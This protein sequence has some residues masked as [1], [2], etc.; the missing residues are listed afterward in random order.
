MV[1]FGGLHEEAPT[2]HL[3]VYY[4]DTNQWEDMT[5][6]MRGQVPSPRFGHSCVVIS[7]TGDMII[8]GGSD[9]NDLF[10]NGRELSSVRSLI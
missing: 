5:G 1:T 4:F 9:G 6:T 8:T 2:N 10:R 3:E 7:T